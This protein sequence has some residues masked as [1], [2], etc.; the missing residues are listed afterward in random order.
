M[1]DGRTL[2]IANRDSGSVSLLDGTALKV[3]SESPLGRRLSDMAVANSRIF[4]TDED[5]GELIEVQQRK[6]TL[7]EVRRWQVGRSPVSVRISADGAWASVACLWPRRVAVVSLSDAKLRPVQV[8][9]PFAPGRQVHTPEGKLLVADSFGDQLAVVDMKLQKVERI[10]RLAGIHNIRGLALDGAG[11]NLLL[12]DQRLHATGHPTRGDIQSGNL[13]TNEL[14]K[15]PLADLLHPLRDPFQNDRAH[16]LGDI[17][18]GA[19]DPADVTE[20]DDGH[21]VVLFSGVDQIA[22]GR[23]EKATW[24]RLSSGKRPTA[25]ALDAP[26]KRAYVANTFGDSITVVDLEATKV[27][28]EVALSEAKDTGLTPEQRGE[29][30][31]YDAS[32]SFEGWYS[33]HSCHSDGHTNGRLNDNLTDGSFGTPKRVLTLLGSK[34]TAPYAWNGKLAELDAQIH[35]SLTST[36]QG[37]TPVKE[38]VRDLVAYLHTLPPPPSVEKA[39]GTADAKQIERGRHLFDSHKCASCHEAPSF[40]TPRTYDV[41][42]HDEAGGTHFNPP[43]LRGVSQGGPFF[44]DGR[45]RTLEE[46]FTRHRHRLAGE[47]SGEELADLLYFLR[48]L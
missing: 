25:L 43:S 34:D 18:Q 48:S 6:G 4:L 45:A 31:F 24:T 26:N 1:E 15:I 10:H 20:T 35:N 12:T 8:D 7:A 36:M 28:R 39:R 19:G 21:I 27:I 40:T 37:P 2:L 33:C 38:R 5:A 47:L 13:I 41:G 9:L 14:R 42:L 11:K 16:P 32:L 44:H 46:V 29:M 22:I 3:V 17:E 30:L 23:P